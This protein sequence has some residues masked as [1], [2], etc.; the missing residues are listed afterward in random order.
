MIPGKIPHPFC[1]VKTEQY[2]CLGTRNWALTRCQT[3]GTPFLDLLASR[4]VSNIRLFLSD[5]VCGILLLQ[6][7]LRWLGSNCSFTTYQIDKLE[8]FLN[9]LYHF[10]FPFKGLVWFLFV[11]F[12]T[13]FLQRL[14]QT[15]CNSLWHTVNAIKVSVIIGATHVHLGAHKSEIKT[16][17][18]FFLCF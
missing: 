8:S 1:H 18:L 6:L 5:P 12:L 10:F 17:L 4:S 16:L 9:F 15:A 11:C 3:V 13:R 2:G 7:E 14:K